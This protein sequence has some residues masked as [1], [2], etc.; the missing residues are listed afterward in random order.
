MTM[1]LPW[2]CDN[3][4]VIYDRDINTHSH[5]PPCQSSSTTRVTYGKTRLDDGM[6]IALPWVTVVHHGSTIHDIG[7]TMDDHD[8]TM[9]DNGTTMG[10]HE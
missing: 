9:Q 6:D 2:N 4:T 10:Y 7:G 1:S 3:G 5:N 8:T